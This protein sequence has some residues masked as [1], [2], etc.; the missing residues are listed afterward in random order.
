MA[1][2]SGDRYGSNEHS[3]MEDVLLLDSHR[4]TKKEQLIACCKPAYHMRKITNK[5]A[6]LLLIKNFF[7]ITLFFYIVR[8]L[9]VFHGIPCFIV[10]GI[11]LPVIGWL[12]DVRLGRHKVI[13]WSM[14]IMWA[15][16]ILAT[17]SSV[18]AQL[19]ESYSAVH[20]KVSWVLVVVA[21]AGFGGYQANVI[22]FGMDQLH[23]ASTDE[24]TSFI[25][26]YVWTSFSGGVLVDFANV[27]A[28]KDYQILTEFM[29]CVS[30]SAALAVSILSDKYLIKEPLTQNPFKLVYNVLKYAIK[31][32]HPRCRSA[33]TYCEDELPSRIDFGKS[34]YGGP[35]TTEQVED[36]KTFIRL[37]FI[38]TFGC[39]IPTLVAVVNSFKER[40]VT[41]FFINLPSELNAACYLN[42]FYALLIYYVVTVLIPLYEFIIYP[43]FRRHFSRV[44]IHHKF[45][46]GVF[47]Q[48]AR[49]ISLMVIITLARHS[50]LKQNDYNVNITCILQEQ[51]NSLGYN[52]D[53]RLFLLPRIFDALSVATLAV[54][55]IEFISAQTP[56]AMRGLITG[57]AYGSVAVFALI[58]YGV[59][60]LFA[61]YS[62]AVDGGLIGCEFWY[63][64]VNLF[65][66]LPIGAVLV[67]LERCYK[68]RKREDVLPNEHIFA[69]RYYA[70]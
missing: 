51:V 36:V 67:I 39:T 47:L 31:T 14:W 45:F 23:D 35:F 6:I 50:Y 60:Q 63:L 24:I 69:E 34:K 4:R 25:S 58:G 57:A 65:F 21:A 32:K 18:V 30:L 27:C 15:G 70:T 38:V 29:V 26:W 56:Y 41:L 8:I 7:V 54:G 17:A 28:P 1:S 3:S 62:F 64:L 44:K 13:Q 37:L 40:L 52:F 49:F 12:A 9:S 68:M 59:R 53:S 20:E 61:T 48:I 22:Q 55:G 2:H 11:T 42:K 43:V 10:W 5:G 19:V 66:I 46:F 16:F 33:F